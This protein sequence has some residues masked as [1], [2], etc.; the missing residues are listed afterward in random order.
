MSRIDYGK[1]A[2]PEELHTLDIEGST[3]NSVLILNKH[4]LL[5][6]GL[7][8]HVL[9]MRETILDNYGFKKPLDRDL[10]W[11]KRKGIL[12]A[13][14]NDSTDLIMALE[15]ENYV[16]SDDHMMSIVDTIRGET[17][18]GG[19]QYGALYPGASSQSV[20]APTKATAINGYYGMSFD[21]TEMA[22]GSGT[23]IATNQTSNNVHEWGI[24]M[25]VT[26]PTDKDSND[27]IVCLGDSSAKPND[28]V[29]RSLTTSTNETIAMRTYDEGIESLGSYLLQTSIATKTDVA[30]NATH[31][32]SI[33]AKYNGTVRGNPTTTPWGRLN[34]TAQT[35]GLGTTNAQG[36]VA[37]KD[38]L[39]GFAGNAIDGY[40]YNGASTVLTEP[41][42][43][44]NEPNASNQTIVRSFF[45][46][47]Y[48]FVLYNYS[49]ANI[50]KIEGYMA[51]KF[52]LE[53]TLPSDHTY[54]NSAPT[55][56]NA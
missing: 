20:R 44:G 32:I 7:Q 38:H 33:G 29:I 5:G 39:N 8:S 42:T 31:I 36:I 41:I 34:G 6:R 51:H 21:G 37:R 10:T 19:Y 13:P 47:V 25:L 9:N 56:S 49:E 45:G 26:I 55:T 14:T 15:A 24:T 46:S 16:F 1:H 43:F 54:K 27:A 4:I 23:G 35:S 18:Y 22:S 40:T 17:I 11:D 52:G 48:E 12:Y 53:S 3:D 28:L 2:L 50:D 30:N